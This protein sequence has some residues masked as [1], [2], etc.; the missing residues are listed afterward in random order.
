MRFLK[1]ISLLFFVCFFYG[2]ADAATPL[3]VDTLPQDAVKVERVEVQARRKNYSKKN[4]AVELLENIRA[5][6]R[7]QQPLKHH[8]YIKF[9][10]YEKIV[11][12]IN[13]FQTIDSTH[14]LSFLNSHAMPNPFSGRI[15]LPISLHER[16]F[17]SQRWSNGAHSDTLLHH[18]N[19]GVDDRFSTGTVLAFVADALPEVD[20]YK[21]NIY[22]AARQFVS[23]LAANAKDF[24]KYFLAP[25]TLIQNGAPHVELS[26]YP[27]S[28]HSLSL[29]GTMVV[30]VDPNSPHTPY[31]VSS[32]ISIPNKT[33]L[34][35][36]SDLY[37]RQNFE[38]DSSGIIALSSDEVSF[39]ASP[40]KEIPMLNVRRT[41]RYSEYQ[42]TAKHSNSYQPLD[43]IGSTP[44]AIALDN[45]KPVEQE[46]M[47]SRVIQEL[48]RQPLWLVTEELMWLLAEGYFETSQPKSYFDIGPVL[49]FATGNS[50]EGTRLSFGGMTTPNI[51]EHIFFDGLIAYGFDDQKIKGRGSLEWSFTPKKDHY[52]QYPRH[53]ISAMA[54]YDVHSFSDG[55]DTGGSSG[56]VFSWA[57]RYSY[58]DLT[59]MRLYSL[60]YTK[61][62]MNDMS[63]QLYGRKYSIYETE[64][65]S[66]APTAGV[67]PHY[68]MSEVE[69]R[70]TFAPGQRLYE[71]RRRRRD[72]N[73]YI[74][75]IELSH[76]TAFKDLLG[77]AYSRNTT[78]INAT[79]RVSLQ[80]FGY[81]DL[82]GEVGAEWNQVPYMLLPHPKTNT[83]YIMGTTS[84][85]S[86]MRPQEYLYDRYVYFG[87]NYHLDGLLMSRIPLIKHL[88]LREMVT[89]RGI[90]GSLSD[91]NNPAYNSELIP[92]AK[93]S[94]PIGL[95]PY[96]E[97][98]VGIDNIFTFLSV[99]YVWRMT[100]LED[101]GIE[102]GAL[103]FDF[104]LKF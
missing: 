13:D 70:Y 28:D 95:E 18:S 45:Y 25:D 6:S 56:D 42:N 61:E 20:I 99:Q 77:G 29:R 47:T 30:N 93:G 21:E 49:D 97:M 38:M 33:D 12:S 50:L 81:I 80:P 72:I 9:Q 11:I 14:K 85:F 5:K 39:D 60:E 75:R 83:S 90:Y 82:L 69:L 63:L 17:E 2:V 15:I 87:A 62:W 1:N 22:L 4:P 53:S 96:I 79:G 86:L 7:T 84:Q 54:S 19:S 65:F 66:F 36:L 27:F 8:D 41:N 73:K 57:K 48:R 94:S 52:K 51:S 32:D 103:L 78:K 55:F 43:T 104:S 67:L 24:Y 3:V 101:P 46:L 74:A 102:H 37:L 34:N 40:V 58:D 89:F 98:G 26:F 92:L 68:D 59:Y 88:N 16:I 31:V 71:T 44:I 10:R 35:F 100:Y 76:T 23:P 64:L 91:S